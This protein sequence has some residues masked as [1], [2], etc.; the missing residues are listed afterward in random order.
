[1]ASASRRRFTAPICPMIA[2]YSRGGRIGRRRRAVAKS[3][4]GQCGAKSANRP[5]GSARRGRARLPTCNP[6]ISE[7]PARKGRSTREARPAM[8]PPVRCDRSF[9][10]RRWFARYSNSFRSTASPMAR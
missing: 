9:S 6:L 8:A 1:M 2:A 3:L 5:A 7:S 10:D 4:L